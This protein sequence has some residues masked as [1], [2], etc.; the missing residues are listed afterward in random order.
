[1]LLEEAARISIPDD[2]LIIAHTAESSFYLCIYGIERVI[3][4]T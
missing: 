1:M 4:S 2:L 3:E